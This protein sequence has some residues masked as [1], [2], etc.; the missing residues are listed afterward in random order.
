MN[1]DLTPAIICKF[2]RFRHYFVKHLG[3]N[4]KPN[5]HFSISPRLSTIEHFGLVLI[6]GLLF[7]FFLFGFHE[8]AYPRLAKYDMF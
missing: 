6:S 5:F 4:E 8:I 1:I 2:A 3:R 7:L